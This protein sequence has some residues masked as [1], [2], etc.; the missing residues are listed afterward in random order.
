VNNYDPDG[1][2]VVNI[3]GAALG[4]ILGGALGKL[5][6]NYYNLSGW[7]RNA[8]IA[9]FVVG[10]AAIGWFTGP[11]VAKL[12]VRLLTSNGILN[13]TKTTAQHMGEAARYV[14]IQILKQAIKGRSYLDPQRSSSKMFYTTMW[15][16]GHKYNLEVLYNKATN[17][18]LHFMY[19][20][21]AI[22][23]LPRI[24]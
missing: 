19:T 5:V 22:G 9:G 3:I 12:A 17:T 14:P 15:K 7:K 1:H 11:V 24:K 20:P 10:G 13:F 2:F 18:I 4:G 23:P 16:N 6:A 21:K 8:T